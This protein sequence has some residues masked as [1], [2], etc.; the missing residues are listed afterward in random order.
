MSDEILIRHCAPTL[1]SIKTGSLFTSRFETEEAMRGSL[2]M[3]NQRL[4]GKGVYAIPLRFRGGVGLIYLYRPHRLE[5][6]LQRQEV[7]R[8][9]ADLGYAEGTPAAQLRDLAQRL[10]STDAFPHEIG[11]FLSY[12]PEDVAGFIRAPG[13]A[14]Y[15]GIGKVYGDVAAAQRTFARYRRCTS[16]LMHR[17]Q[18]GSSIEQLAAGVRA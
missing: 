8:L 1:A 4:R 13:E 5:K 18:Q 15:T 14:K 11:L 2:R 9:L 6:D 3:L 10:R 7:V 12:P 16:R 17:W